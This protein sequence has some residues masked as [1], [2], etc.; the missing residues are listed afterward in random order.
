MHVIFSEFLT[1]SLSNLL[2]PNQARYDNNWQIMCVP[3]IFMLVKYSLKVAFAS[4][5]GCIVWSRSGEPEAKCGT[6]RKTKNHE[7]KEVLPLCWVKPTHL[8]QN[9]SL[10]QLEREYDTLR[11]GRFQM[12]HYVMEDFK[13]HVTSW[14]ISNDTLR[15]GRFQ[16]TCYVTEDLGY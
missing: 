2:M 7:C 12:T 9:V 1:I 11:H 3:F 4:F 5:H 14:K 10:S 16:M 15:H 6:K 8:S 13:W